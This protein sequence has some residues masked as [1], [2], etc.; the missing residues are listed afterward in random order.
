MKQLLLNLLCV[1]YTIEVQINKASGHFAEEKYI[2]ILQMS[3]FILLSTK[4]Y[5]ENLKIQLLEY[6]ECLIHSLHV[7]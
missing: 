5:S 6:Q 2:L 4:M 7:V 3:W 1:Q